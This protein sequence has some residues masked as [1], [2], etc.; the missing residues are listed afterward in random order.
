MM[1]TGPQPALRPRHCPLTWTGWTC[2]SS[3][4]SIG[5]GRRTLS[6]GVPPD[7]ALVAALDGATQALE[8]CVRRTHLTGN[9]VERDLYMRFAR[10]DMQ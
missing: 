6:Q 7:P 5:I 4:L 2:A 9:E 10:P 1:T 8:L 3:A